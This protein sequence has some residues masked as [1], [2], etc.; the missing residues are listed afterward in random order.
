MLRRVVAVGL[1]VVAALALGAWLLLSQ[2]RA[3]VFDE[4]Y[5]AGE[6]ERLDS[7]AF[8]T[9]EVYAA[10][11]DHALERRD[12]PL[13]EAL[14]GLAI[15]ADE[16]ARRELL[17]LLHTA[18]PAA[19][20]QT[21]AEGLLAG[22]V[23]YLRGEGD[24]F[25]IEP[26]LGERLEALAGHEA[27]EPSLLESAF[28][29]LGLGELVVAH[30][31][32]EYAPAGLGAGVARGPGATPGRALGLAAGDPS[33]ETAAAGEWFSAE[34]FAAV[35]EIVPYLRGETES[36][37]VAVDF[38]GY[39]AL[40]VPL[41]SLLQRPP[42]ELAAE[43]YRFD[44]ADLRAEL[45]TVEDEALQ[46]LDELRAALSPGWTVDE[47]ELL[48]LDEDPEAA[49]EVADGRELMSTLL[50]P[51][52][53]GSLALAALL[54]VAV[55]L[56]GGRSWGSRLAWGAAAAL[57]AALGVMVLA[58]AGYSLLLEPAL[59]EGWL[60]ATA[61]WSDPWRQF[62][63]RL[64]TDLERAFAR[65]A[66]GLAWRALPVAALASVALAAGLLLQRRDARAAAGAEPP[67]L[68]KAEVPE[69]LA[70]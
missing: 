40:A 62:G 34:L 61:D 66:R 15:P 50:G 44:E 25:T 39:E 60:E 63:P 57:A 10:L 27:G 53:W 12:D 29:E 9:G 20:L 26:R 31:V 42:S 14:G 45:R 55:G 36:F 47:R 21:Q 65:I 35:D 68:P 48:N 16:A 6:L 8:V 30:L 43:G 49:Q 70:A 1:A 69:R 46:D 38:E 41:A 13:P 7:Y 54:L 18:A 52:R 67:M 58:L 37:E 19:V 32:A 11:V 2:A 64:V 22:L 17:L 33:F 23:P 4:G 28:R 59:R 51:L 5:I 24:G 3:T 56:L